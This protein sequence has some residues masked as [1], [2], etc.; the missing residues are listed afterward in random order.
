MTLRLLQQ[1]EREEAGEGEIAEVSRQADEG[2]KVAG[3]SQ[4]QKRN[5]E[6]KTELR[7]SERVRRKVIAEVIVEGLSG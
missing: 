5:C 6:E 1:A 4:G 3:K 2:E 7:E